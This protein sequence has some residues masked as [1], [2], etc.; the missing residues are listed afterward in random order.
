MEFN[1]AEIMGY[2]QLALSVILAGFGVWVL[3]CLSPLNDDLAELE[4]NWVTKQANEKSKIN[5]GKDLLKIRI[6]KSTTPESLIKKANEYIEFIDDMN[7]KM[8]LYGA[9][10]ILKMVFFV[11]LGVLILSSAYALFITWVDGIVD[12]AEINLL[13]TILTIHQ[14]SVT[15]LLLMPE[16]EL[17]GVLDSHLTYVPTVLL[18]WIAP[19]DLIAMV[20]FIFKAVVFIFGGK[21][22]QKTKSKLQLVKKIDEAEL[23]DFIKRKNNDKADKKKTPDDW[24]YEE[25]LSV[26]EMPNVAAL[27]RIE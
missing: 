10:L 19:I 14:N 1:Q 27:R 18:S 13:E 26:E 17:V 3:K 4:E 2:L 7:A 12:L 24:W 21:R 5:K 23:S 25:W 15:S 22:W 20:I 6:T 16:K 11:L 8:S 9:W